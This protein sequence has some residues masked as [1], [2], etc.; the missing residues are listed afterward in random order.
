[1]P[2]MV[3][4]RVCRNLE[5]IVLQLLQ[6][7]N[8]HNLL[9]GGGVDD[10]EVAE[11]EVLHYGVAQVHR[12]LFAIFV[13]ECAVKLLHMGGV[14]HIARLDDDGQIGSAGISPTSSLPACL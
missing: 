9:A 5:N 4:Q 10:Y 6:I 2:R 8:A 3:E 1:M 12:Q 11:A 7:M 13:E 14:L